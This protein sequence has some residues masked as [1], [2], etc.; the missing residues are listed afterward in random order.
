MYKENLFK[1]I[2]NEEVVIWAGSGFSLYAGF[3]SGK[4][5]CE[6][7]LKDLSEKERSKISNTTILDELA[8]EYYRIK[9]N[10]RNSL[11]RLL[12]S[13]FEDRNPKSTIYHDKIASI[14]HFKCVITTNYDTLFETAYKNAAQVIFSL[15]EY[16]I[17]I[18]Q[19]S[20]YLR[21]MEIYLS[22]IA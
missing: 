20:R 17:L 3:P 15:Q 19:K 12:K 1:L 13:V 2:R 22:Q 10:N 9:G 6:I 21:F 5:L 14:P 18:N 7:L 16:P 8:E 4:D 11:I